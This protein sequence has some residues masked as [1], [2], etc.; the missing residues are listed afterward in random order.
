METKGNYS[1]PNPC[2]HYKCCT[3]SPEESKTCK[4]QGHFLPKHLEIFGM[5]FIDIKDIQMKRDKRRQA[6]LERA[7]QQ[8][9]EALRNVTP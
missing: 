4:A 5:S 7:A 2:N 9:K 3:L 1:C 8:F 6:V